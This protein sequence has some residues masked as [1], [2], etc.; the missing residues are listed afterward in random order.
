MYYN[1]RAMSIS[2]NQKKL[3]ETEA[4]AVATINKDGSPHLIAVGYTR[5]INSTTVVITDNFMKQTPENIK[6]DSRIC[7]AV[8][9]KDWKEGYRFVGNAE[10]QT[11]GKYVD[12]VKTMKVNEGYPA[13][14]ALVVT[15][16]NIQKLG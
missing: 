3:L 9:S 16:D 15:V 7:L 5:V 8:W 1:V 2:E 11:T 6:N 14:G 4:L 13:K 10:Y 12:Y